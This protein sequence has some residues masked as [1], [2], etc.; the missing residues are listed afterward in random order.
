MFYKDMSYELKAKAV[1]NIFNNMAL[2]QRNMNCFLSDY[3]H[4]RE[5]NK[6]KQSIRNLLST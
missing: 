6:L 1:M 5:M 4:E 2:Y 3:S